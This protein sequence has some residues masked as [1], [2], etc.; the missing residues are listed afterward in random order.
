MKGA[1]SILFTLAS[2]ILLTLGAFSQTADNIGRITR[3][4]DELYSRYKLD[5]ARKKYEEGYRLSRELNNQKEAARFLRKEGDMSR[6][7]GDVRTA[8]ECYD[9][10][11]IIW[12]SIKDRE[13]EIKALISKG[14]YLNYLGQFRKALECHGILQEICDSPGRDGRHRR[15][16]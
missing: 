6:R 11:L 13:G 12:V 16:D 1:F 15:P 7:L 3:E 14:D 10:S 8:L 9:K 5:E 4:G 2:M